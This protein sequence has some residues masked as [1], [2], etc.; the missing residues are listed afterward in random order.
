M[1]RDRHGPREKRIFSQFAE[2]CPLPIQSDSIVKRNP[3]E[4][5]ILCQVEGEGTVAFEMVEIIDSG[6]ARRTNEGLRLER[7][8]SKAREKL[9]NHQR[10][11]I[12]TRLGDALVLVKFDL[13][14]SARIRTQAVPS[15]LESLKQINPS[16]KGEISRES[17]FQLEKGVKKILIRR[18]NYDGPIIR[19]AAAGTHSESTIEAIEEKLNH[20]YESSA[21]IELLAHYERQPPPLPEWM[22]SLQRFVAS[23]VPNSNFR[24]VWVLDVS[25]EE[26]VLKYPQD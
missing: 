1:A 20:D 2:V 14:S 5:D 10:S 21:P 24:R 15:V 9:S 8:F 17:G 13:T 3:P 23:C 16:F 25:K 11:E 7:L 19:V 4:P 6:L 18:G 26:I 22:P 12:G